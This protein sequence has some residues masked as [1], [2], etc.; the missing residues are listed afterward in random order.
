MT[1]IEAIE[2]IDKREESLEYVDLINKCLLL[3]MFNLVYL[4]C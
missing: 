4:S 3:I 2:E 1:P